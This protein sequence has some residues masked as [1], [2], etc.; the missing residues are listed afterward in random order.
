MKFIVTFKTPDAVRTTIE[1]VLPP[2]I[3][4]DNEEEELYIYK[5][6]K[7][8][9][10]TAKWVKYGECITIEFDTEAGTA[11]VVPKN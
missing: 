2:A 7:L 4:G 10:F 9:E 8:V 5:V 11:T 3:Q 6:E 1:N